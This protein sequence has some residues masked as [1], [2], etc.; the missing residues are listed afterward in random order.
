MMMQR[1]SRDSMPIG[2]SEE[3]LNAMFD[4]HEQ[5]LDLAGSAELGAPVRQ[6]TPEELARINAY[7]RMAKEMV[8]GKREVRTTPAPSAETKAAPSATDAYSEQLARSMKHA[9][10]LSLVQKF[11]N[12]A[13]SALSGGEPLCAMVVGKNSE[14]ALSSLYGIFSSVR[15]AATLLGQNNVAMVAGRG[16]VLLCV[17]RHNML[18]PTETHAGL[19]SETLTLLL[20]L[21]DRVDKEGSDSSCYAEAQMMLSLYAAAVPGTR[22]FHPTEKP[23]SAKLA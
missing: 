14:W 8:D 12:Q 15:Y 3:S 1:G 13:S 19:L 21:F 6:K 17:L 16:E 5:T 18:S 23:T 22:N 20:A 2:F 4:Q 10:A 9:A 11:R 7:A